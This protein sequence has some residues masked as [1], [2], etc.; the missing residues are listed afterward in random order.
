MLKSI[1]YVLSATNLTGICKYADFHGINH[2]NKPKKGKIMEEKA[3]QHFYLK[4]AYLIDG[5]PDYR[6]NYYLK[7]QPWSKEHHWR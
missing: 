1:L 5:C 2:L 6:N 7:S 3:Q 4:A